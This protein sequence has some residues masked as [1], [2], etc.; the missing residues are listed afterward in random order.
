MNV[1]DIFITF[2]ILNQCMRIF[3]YQKHID[4]LTR[5]KIKKAD[6]SKLIMNKKTKKQILKNQKTELSEKQK[7]ESL[8]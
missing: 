4:V 2:N 6:I 1:F 5:K 3:K 7:I 8:K